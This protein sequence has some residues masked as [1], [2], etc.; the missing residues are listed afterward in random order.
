MAKY[1]ILNGIRVLDLSQA[2]AGGFCTQIL[3]DLGAEVIKVEP[4][5]LGDLTRAGP[6]V[7]KEPYYFLALNR[8]KKSVTLDVQTASGK[9][10]FFDLVK[11]ADVIYS[12]MR[13]QAIEHLGISYEEV[14][15]INPSIITCYVTAF[16]TTGPYSDRVGWDDVVQAVSGIS[17]LTVDNNHTPV[18]TAVAAGDVSG[19][20]FAVIGIISALYRRKETGEGNKVELNL[21]DTS[22]ALMPQMFQYYFITQKPPVCVGNKHSVIAGFGFFKTRNGY[23][24]LGPCWPRIARAI[25]K[26]ELMEDPRFKDNAQ[27]I[28]HKDELNAEIEKGLSV[29]DTEDWMNIMVAE[30]IPASPVNDLRG[31]ECDPQVIQNKAI[32]TLD[33]PSRGKMKYID[34][35]I[36]MPNFTEEQAQPCPELGQ[37]TEELLRELLHYSEEE[38]AAIHRES[39]EHSAELIRK[40]VRK[41]R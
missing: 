35:P 40:S 19:A 24:A 36:N 30:D 15:K 7:Q 27:R 21:I 16:G 11:K 29:A 5:K 12:N 9:K 2:I 33:D 31:V 39:E 20:M 13:K 10:A 41:E 22:M 3:G 4:P 25:N 6:I 17:S 34:L 38:I 1:N 26:E 28:I 14:K 32:K 8:N 18:R 23:I 37:H